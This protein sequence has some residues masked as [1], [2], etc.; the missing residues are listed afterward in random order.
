MT[1]KRW[2][3]SL[4][5]FILLLGITGCSSDQSSDLEDAVAA[6]V[7]ATQTK[8][9]WEA[10]VEAAQQTEAAQE[11]TEPPT[12]TPEPEIVH[13]MYPEEPSET[14]N[15]YVTDFN[16]IDFAQEGI[17]YS[18]QFFVN[19]YERPFTQE[20]EE[21]K[22]YLDLILTNIKVNPP[23]L[24]ADI[25]LADE[26]PEESSAIYSLEFDTDED[27]RGDYL[28]SAAMPLDDMWTV[29]GVVVLEDGNEDV[30]GSNPLLADP[31]EES[32]DYDGYEIELFREGQGE[33]PDLAWVRRN[34]MDDT[35]LQIAVKLP[36]LGGGGF[37]WSVWADE[38]L[39]D[40]ALADYNDRFNFEQAGSPYPDHQY[41]PI[42]QI[43]LVDSTCRS[44]Y[45]FEPEG[46]EV[47]ICQIYTPG[48]GYRL[49]LTYVIG[50]TPYTVC[51]DVC[52]PNCPPNLP[53]GYFCRS[54][55]LSE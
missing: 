21:Y 16:S 33:D 46:D 8:I 50:S 1:W 30:G 51:N 32:T 20:M 41:Y 17:T 43:N 42:Q 49:C 12:D 29:R 6:G 53:S 48:E 3:I 5:L 14:S 22:G 9:A 36:L 28:V 54:C 10:S 25:F 19:R 2:W 23:W 7:S 31:P 35:S 13:L 34:P 47:G 4:S 44:W 15:T 45:G 38:G 52:N 27:G 24:Y 18:D 40:P 55:T 11:D 26:L 37:F 39:T